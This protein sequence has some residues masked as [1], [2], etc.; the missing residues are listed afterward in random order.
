VGGAGTAAVPSGAALDVESGKVGAPD[1]PSGDLLVAGGPLDR[2]VRS[3]CG[4]RWARTGLREFDALYRAAVYPYSYNAPSPVPLHEIASFNPFGMFSGNP[5]DETRQIYG[6]RTNEGRWA[7]VQAVNVTLEHIV[8]R[9]ITWEKALASVQIIGGFECPKTAL[10]SFGEVAELGSPAFVR[11]PALGVVSEN[12]ADIAGKAD[13]CGLFRDAVRA[14]TPA[15][16]SIDPV[17]EAIRALPLADRRIGRFVGDYER[18]R[19]PRARFNAATVGIGAGR[20]AAWQVNGTGLSGLAGTVD[21]G[22]GAKA[23]YETAGTS[24]IITLNVDKPVEMRL[25]VT[26][27]DDAGQV[28]AAT[29]CVR[30]DPHCRGSGRVTPAWKDYQRAWTG[31]FGVVETRFPATAIH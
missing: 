3:M 11:S 27:V 21:L 26:V 9:Y 24:V 8:F 2:I 5:F 31:N 6:V 29:R 19:H 18:K 14:V 7:A 16:V 1:M 17:G 23:E 4:A 10:G 22:G 28:A 25:S 20:K 30:Y 13:P 15:P 12:R